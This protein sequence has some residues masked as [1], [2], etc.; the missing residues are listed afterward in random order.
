MKRNHTDRRPERKGHA[1]YTKRA[2]LPYQ[3]DASLIAWE[4]GIAR[5]AATLPPVERQREI[6]DE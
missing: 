6:A 1:P 3:Y 2:K 4:R 5:K